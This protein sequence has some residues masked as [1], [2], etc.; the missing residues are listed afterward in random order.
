MS[1]AFSAAEL[2]WERPAFNR[3]PR[4]GGLPVLRR[5]F[6]QNFLACGA[7]ASARSEEAEA[8]QYH[9]ENFATYTLACVAARQ[10]TLLDEVDRIAREVWH[11]RPRGLPLVRLEEGRHLL[12]RFA[13]MYPVEL[14]AI[15]KVEFT[16]AHNIG[17]AILTGTVDAEYRD[18]DEDPDDPPRIIRIRDHKT[19]WSVGDHDFQMR[20]YACL[21]FLQPGAQDLEEIV[22]EIVY[23]RINIDP[24]QESYYREDFEHGELGL[25]WRE[26]VLAPLAARWPQRR[27]ARPVGGVACQYCA[28]RLTC[29]QAIGPAASRPTNDSEFESFF[30]DVLR[31]E[32]E[33]KE[34]RGIVRDYFK[35]RQPHVVLG[36]DVGN[37]LPKEDDA[38]FVVKPGHDEDVI[39]YMNEVSAGAGELVRRRGVS[40]KLVPELFWSKLISLGYAEKVPKKTTPGWRK[41]TEAGPTADDAVALG[42]DSYAAA[43]AV[44]PEDSTMRVLQGSGG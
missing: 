27:R 39:V 30:S 31:K 18:D 14:R 20:F 16:M 21:R 23:P 44:G 40:V 38:D 3:I 43:L 6:V 36:H 26:E 4:V 33:L 37:L 2:R 5:T 9:H 34:M 12:W 41:H 25:W 1:V 24:I 15:R 7:H 8:G 32:A 42:D 35:A 19:P 29:A 17:W 10:D 11:R 22:A 28:R 13:K